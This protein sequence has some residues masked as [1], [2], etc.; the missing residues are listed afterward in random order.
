MKRNPLLYPLL[1]TLALAPMVIGSEVRA[2]SVDPQTLSIAQV[3]HDQAVK[4]MDRGEYANACPNLEEVV[5]LIPDGMG[6]KLTLAECYEHS[7][8][9]ASAWITYALVDSTATKVSQVQY[10]KKAHKRAEALQPQLAQFTIVVP[11]A[12]RTIPGIEIKRDGVSV[13]QVQWG[14]PLP[15]DRGKH[16]VV[17]TATNKQRWEKSIEI[18]ADGT[19]TSV[20]IEQLADTKS[21]VTAP[22]V[23]SAMEP[24]PTRPRQTAPAASPSGAWRKAGLVI[25]GVGLASLGIGAA[26]GITAIVK[27]SESNRDGHCH[28][29]NYCDPTGIPI[30]DA[31]LTAGTVSTAMFIAGGIALAGGI[32]LFVTSPQT[33]MVANTKVGVGPKG[34]EVLVA[35]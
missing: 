20:T 11:E 12:V 28:D 22:S 6:A 16:F 34:L 13:G 24:A 2:Q 9:L 14:I 33:P 31:G 4:A 7:G 21:V 19:S 8:R 17:A 35:W 1:T 30:R 5:R 29:G 15:V 32:T 27:Q 3:L 23:S 10:K 18:L 25:G 26:F